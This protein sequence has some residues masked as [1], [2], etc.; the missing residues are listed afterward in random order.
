MARVLCAARG[1]GGRTARYARRVRVRA[2]EL[3]ILAGVL[4]GL[5]LSAFALIMV[6]Y[7][8]GGPA[9]ILVG[10]AAASPAVVAAAA[11]VRP[12]VA[13]GP[14]AFALMG[15]LALAPILLLVPS[16]AGLVSQLRGRG[17]QT[18]LP[19]AEAAYPWALAL[20]LTGAFAGLGVARHR[21]GDRSSRR[22]R[23]VAGIALGTAASL[24][25]GA[26]FASAAVYN[27]LALRDRATA[28]SRFGPTDP[29][30]EPPPCDGPLAVGATATVSLAMDSAVDGRP[31]GQLEVDGTRSGADIRWDGYVTGPIAFGRIGFTRVGGAAW[32]LAPN[33]GWVALAPPD[34]GGAG[35]LD[36][37]LL[38]EA[39][40]PAQRAVVEDAGLAFI[41]GARARH[42]RVALDG[43]T[44]QRAL[45][46]VALLVGRA[47]LS[48]WRGSL[49]YWAFADGALGQADGS[50][51]GPALGLAPGALTAEVRFRITAI[52]RGDPAAIRPPG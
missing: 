1:R 46:E 8:P 36:R 27:E 12:P 42:C 28:A 33:Y 6:G 49:D 45:P 41:E 4:T 20:L 10:V 48:R 31:T 17:P 7:R 11:L 37:A 26:L 50:V 40:S 16:I 3:R 34:D 43:A 21:L 13:R 2:I 19:S 35:D 32:S 52:D 44:L 15:W 22:R 38:R 30:L 9:D 51:D 5:W 29:A 18:L 47:D 39:L 25:S 24:V 23:L 14:R